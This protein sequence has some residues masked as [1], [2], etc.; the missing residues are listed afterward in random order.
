MY[1]DFLNRMQSLLMREDIS[2]VLSSVEEEKQHKKSQ[3]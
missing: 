3:S 2:I 1:N